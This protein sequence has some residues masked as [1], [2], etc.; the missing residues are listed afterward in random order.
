MKNPLVSNYFTANPHLEFLVNRMFSWNDDLDTFRLILMAAGEISAREFSALL[1]E[2]GEC[3]LE[4]VGGYNTVKI[5][6][7]S[8]R[9]LR[10]S[11]QQGWF[12]TMFP[13]EYG[14]MGLP[15]AVNGGINLLLSEADIGSF[16]TIGLT[17]GVAETFLR[18]GSRQLKDKYVRK[19]IS[20]EP[21][22]ALTGAMLLTEP[23]A[24][25]DVGNCK[26]KAVRHGDVYRIFGE[27]C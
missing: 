23:N 16:I 17:Q 2:T 21:G 7:N 1:K 8:E 12:G 10:T 18:Y 9:V 14:G 4:K 5:P 13:I 19:L 11:R 26:T 24:G 3:T 25:S 27:K 6:E 20:D 15:Q 22:I